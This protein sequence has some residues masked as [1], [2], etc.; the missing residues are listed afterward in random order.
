MSTPVETP[1]GPV[2]VGLRMPL[3]PAIRDV[4][5]IARQAEEMGCDSVWL[6]DHLIWPVEVHSRY[7][8]SE[9]GAAPLPPETPFFDPWVLLAG[10]AEATTT[11]RLATGVYVLP[12]RHHLVT[13]RAVATLDSLSDGRVIFGVGIGWLEE[14][15]EAADADY[16]TRAARTDDIIDALRVLWQPGPA[17]REGPGISFRP[18]YLEPRPP[19]GAQL[20]I[21]I[22][23]ESPAALRRAANSGDGWLSMRHSP[24]SARGQIAALHELRAAAGRRAQ[25]FS[26]T[27]QGPWPCERAVIEDFAAAGVDRLVFYP[28][29][30][31]GDGWKADLSAFRSWFGTL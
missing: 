12:L 7:P 23:G 21:Y 16:R 22:G 6:S 19:Q 18:L 9:T 27:L 31:P 4:I 25:P 24:S 29:E 30:A 10:I 3:G 17:S 20:P 1:A 2:H 28:W 11:V 13:A 5:G 8:Y 14:E 15:F 26:V